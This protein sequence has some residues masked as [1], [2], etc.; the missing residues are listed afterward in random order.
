[1][2]QVNVPELRG[3]IIVKGY[4]VSR[5]ALEMG[6][7]RNTLAHYLAHPE[8]ITYKTMNLFVSKLQLNSKEAGEI[9]FDNKLTE[10]QDTA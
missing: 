3:R 4:T 8:N 6:I 5:L 10:T 7:S 9:F 2:F 1:M